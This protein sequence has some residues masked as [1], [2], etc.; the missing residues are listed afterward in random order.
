MASKKNKP[1]QVRNRQRK[2]KA[3]KVHQTEEILD[4]TGAAS[5]SSQLNKVTLIEGAISPITENAL[6]HKMICHDRVIWPVDERIK[7]M[8]V[9]T[10]K[11]DL[12][13]FEGVV[14]QSA[15]RNVLAMEGQNLKALQESEIKPIPTTVQQTQVNVQ[16]NGNGVANLDV[17]AVELNNDTRLARIRFILEQRGAREVAGQLESR[18]EGSGGPGANGNASDSLGSSTGTTDESV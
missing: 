17:S 8:T 14:R 9:E 15:V 12:N 1:S 4:L 18:G 16:V 7:V 10:V 3:K 5:G 13:H 11:R 2:N 6:I